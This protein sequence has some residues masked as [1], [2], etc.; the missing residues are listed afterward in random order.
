MKKTTEIKTIQGIKELIE[1]KDVQSRYLAAC[2]LRGNSLHIEER[3]ARSLLGK[4]PIM[5][6][7]KSI[8][9]AYDETGVI[10]SDILPFLNPKNKYQISQNGQAKLQY[11]I[12]AL[13]E[14][15]IPN[16]LDKN[17]KKY[18]PWFEKTSSGWRVSSCAGWAD[19]SA[20]VGFGLHY[21]SEELALFGGNIFLPQYIEWL[22][23]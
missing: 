20:D 5:E 18:F 13:N 23:E 3:M 9:D 21:K 2:F 1:S 22:P 19:G 12:L 7:I 11:G 14:G 16:F 4:I 17:Q 6:R 10:E 8:S 15:W